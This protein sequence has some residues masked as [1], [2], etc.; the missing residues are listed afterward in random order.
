MD[1]TKV[2]EYLINR[3]DVTFN[4]IIKDLGIKNKKEL[5]EILKELEREKWIIKSW[6][7]TDEEYEYDPGDKQYEEIEELGGKK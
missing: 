6:C 5:K 4:Q 2:K 3:F 7:K 1:K